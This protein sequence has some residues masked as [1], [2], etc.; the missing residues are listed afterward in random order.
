[1]AQLAREQVRMTRRELRGRVVLITGAAGG[2]GAAL[3]RRYAAA[4]ARIA[5]LDLDAAG[6][7]AGGGSLRA[8]GT[9]ALALP[10]DITDPAACNAVVAQRWRISAR[11][12][13]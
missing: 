4:G 6:S 7:R 3:C 10:G 2:L 1:V 5:A 8:K 12:T 11:S 13:A 9:E